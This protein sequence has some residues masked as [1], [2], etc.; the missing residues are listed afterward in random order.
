MQIYD[1]AKQL[2]IIIYLTILASA[3]N[4]IRA[5]NTIKCLSIT[6]TEVFPLTK[7]STD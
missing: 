5:F 1:W 3:M 7:V 2:N 4:F 6:S